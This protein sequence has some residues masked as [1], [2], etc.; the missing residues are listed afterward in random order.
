MPA[1]RNPLITPA[2][3]HA[4]WRLCERYLRR[5]GNLPAAQRLAR[6][7]GHEFATSKPRSTARRWRSWGDVYRS[8]LDIKGWDQSAA[9]WQAD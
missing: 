9:A 2:M 4:R 7:D 8:Y 5:G 1:K 6:M 3:R